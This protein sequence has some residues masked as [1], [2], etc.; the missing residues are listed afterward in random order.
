MAPAPQLR[1][2]ESLDHPQPAIGLFQ[3]EP[4]AHGVLAPARALLAAM[5]PYQWVKNLLVLVPLFTAHA[6]TQGSAVYA[7]L[8]LL[9]GWSLT[10]SAVY[11]VNDLMD[12]D[13]D[14]RHPTKCYRPFASN[15]LS[16]ASGICATL[17]L[18]VAGFAFAYAASPLAAG[19]VLAYSGVSHLYSIYFKTVP[20]LDGFILSSLYCVRIIAGGVAVGHHVSVWL[21]AFSSFL[22]LSLAFLKRCG[23]LKRSLT[24]GQQNVR[25][26][27]YHVDDLALITLFGVASGFMASHVL[28]VYLNT[29]IAK[30]A[31]RTPAALWGIVPLLLFWLCRLWLAAHRGAM[32]DDPI[33]FS[34]KDRT[35]WGLFASMAIC[36]FI[37]KSIE[38]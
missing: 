6:Y 24:M 22:F 35:T 27:G 12:L 33:V 23:E 14:R 7:S 30:A 29:D 13:A 28:F 17:V 26:R 9:T 8:L 36:F 18:S 11:L 4:A 25:R 10:A 19:I 5:R 1:S 3:G 38:F 15:Q 34:T 37:A 32:H 21:L 20:I 2:G 16:I 31:Y